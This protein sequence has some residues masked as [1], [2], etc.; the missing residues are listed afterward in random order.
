MP[1]EEHWTGILETWVLVQ[2]LPMVLMPVTYLQS[3]DLGILPLNWAGSRV[4]VVFISYTNSAVAAHSTVLR[5]VLRLFCSSEGKW[6]WLMSDVCSRCRRQD[7][8]VLARDWPTHPP[9]PHSSLAAS[10]HPSSLY[11]PPFSRH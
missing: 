7:L 6:S 8:D 5:S 11:M 3:L 4:Q 2:A 9:R 10:A 1:G